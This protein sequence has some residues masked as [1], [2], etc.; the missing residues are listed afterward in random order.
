MNPLDPIL[1]LDKYLAAIISAFGGWVYA[2]LFLIIFLETGVVILPFLPGDS[3]LFAAGALAALGVLDVWILWV[4][5]VIA[6]VLG[7]TLNYW[8]GAK[9]GPRVFKK[10][11]GIFF[12]REYLTKTNAYFNSYGKKTIILA[13]FIPIVR[14]FAPFVAGIGNMN[15]AKFLSYNII[16]ALL[17]VTLFVFG[18]YYFG[19]LPFIKNNFGIVIVAIIVISLLPIVCEIMYHKLWKKDVVAK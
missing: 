3:L 15:Y 11:Y 17:W 10:D 12:R 14:T 5:L 2:L 16:G 18:G 9:I 6:A 4:I 13:R 19:N 7:D 1:H 8:I